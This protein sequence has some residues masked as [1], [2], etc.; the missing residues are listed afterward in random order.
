M[1]RDTPGLTVNK[2]E[3]KLGIKASG[4]CMIHFDNVRVRIRDKRIKPFACEYIEILLFLSI[5]NIHKI[6]YLFYYNSSK[7]FRYLKAKSWVN[8]D[9]DT[10]MLLDS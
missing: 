4:T 8:L 5:I 6:N 1:D 3:E 2:P 7:F 9:M 10:N